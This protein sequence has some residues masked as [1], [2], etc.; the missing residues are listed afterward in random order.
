MN[1]ERTVEQLR[2]MQA[3]SLEEK[4]LLAQGRIERWYYHFHGN[5]YVSFSGGKDSTVLLHIARE[6]FPD[7]PAVFIN[8]GLEY[9]EI[10]AFAMSFDNVRELYPVWGRAARKHGKTPSD[11][12]TFRD[13]LTIYGYPLISKSVSNVI[14]ESRRTKHGSRWDRLHGLYGQRDDGKKSCYDHSRYLPLYDLPIRISDECCKVNKKS[15]AQRYETMTG[16]K[17]IIATMTEESNMRESAWLSSGCNAFESHRP[18]SKPMSFWLEQDVLQ[19]IVENNIEISSVYG[20]VCVQDESK[21]LYTPSFMCSGKLVCSGCQRTGCMFCSFGA[22][23]EKGMTRYQRLKITHPKVYEYCIGGG[24]W[25]ENDRYDPAKTASDD[26]NP[27]HIWVPSKGGLGF[28]KVF[29][30]LNS[31]YGNE[32]IRYE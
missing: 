24:A 28:G 30:M 13:V 14:V 21:N 2:E 22:H 32:F 31:I 27:K 10:R 1:V 15:P 23:L 17:P 6:M 26:W 19:Y 20:D 5:V 7:V 16:N 12:I 11:R 9:P 4:I 8:T 29:D 18:V 3:M 25:I